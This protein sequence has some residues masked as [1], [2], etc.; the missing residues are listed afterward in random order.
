MLIHLILPHYNSFSRSSFIYASSLEKEYKKMGHTVDVYSCPHRE[1][2]PRKVINSLFTRYIRY[3]QRL[4]SKKKLFSEW[5]VHVV[6]H[7]YAYLLGYMRKYRTVVTCHDIIPLLFPKEVGIVPYMLF[8]MNM[9]FLPYAKAIIV[10]SKS[11]KK[12]LEH[13]LRIDGKK[14]FVSYHG[15]GS[16][17]MWYDPEVNNK[18]EKQVRTLLM[19]WSMFYKNVMRTLEALAW[20]PSEMRAWWRLI[21]IKPFT[22]SERE[23]IQANLR[24]VEIVEEEDCSFKKLVEYYKEADILLFASLYE[25]FGLPVLE[26]M[27]CGTVVVS[28]TTASL[29]EVWWDAVVYVD[30]YDIQSIKDWILSVCRDTGLRN[31]LRHAGLARAKDFS[32]EKS[33]NQNIH[34]YT[35]VL[36]V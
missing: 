22:K 18:D 30:P 33:A 3:P 15:Y 11:T 31:K 23:Y 36:S 26:A 9:L 35:N 14:V 12:D 21:K 34:V 1:Y 7:S 24:D 10:P 16:E 19:I 6:D 5:V 32:R 27:S 4:L 13:I 29:P 2:T 28:S 17:L 20:L 8:R 25:G